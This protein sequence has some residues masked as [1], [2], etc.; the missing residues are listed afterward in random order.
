MLEF[1]FNIEIKNVL[2]NFVM[3]LAI[4]DYTPEQVTGLNNLVKSY[5]STLEKHA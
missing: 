4:S 3:Y 1:N 2:E 5:Q